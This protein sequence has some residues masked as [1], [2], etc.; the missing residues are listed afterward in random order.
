MLLIEL[1]F[2]NHFILKR[3]KFLTA[4]I[5][6]DLAWIVHKSLKIMFKIVHFG[7]MQSVIDAYWCSVFRFWNNILVFL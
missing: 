6:I 4:A 2:R 7:V 5:F 1:G 3:Y